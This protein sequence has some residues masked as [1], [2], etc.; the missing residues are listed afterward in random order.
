[1]SADPKAKAE[2]PAATE[3]KGPETTTRPSPVPS[4]SAEQLTAGQASNIEGSDPTGL[5]VAIAA[6]LA[7]I[8]V[9]AFFWL[10]RSR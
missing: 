7:A 3:A 1:M 10:R 9:S 6:V 8:A 4:K 5:L 2:V